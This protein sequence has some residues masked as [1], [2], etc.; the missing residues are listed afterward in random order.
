MDVSNLPTCE[1]II[2]IPRHSN[3]SS[4]NFGIN[5]NYLEIYFFFLYKEECKYHRWNCS[6]TGI[7]FLRKMN[8]LSN[9]SP[10]FLKLIFYNNVDIKFIEIEVEIL[11][12]SNSDSK[13][14]LNS[15]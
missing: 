7:D 15:I 3:Q 13:K 5:I 12:L 1:V 11:K 8:E 9:L 14:N 4:Q 2:K 6:F 10:K